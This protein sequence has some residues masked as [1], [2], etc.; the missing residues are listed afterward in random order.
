MHAAKA[1]GWCTESCELSSGRTFND[2]NHP[3]GCFWNQQPS[4][5]YG[6]SFNF[7]FS[8]PAMRTWYTA[9]HVHFVADGMDFWWNDEGET[10]WFT[11]LLWN[12]AQAMQFNQTAAVS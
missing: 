5:L 10:A 4:S 8:L 9:T 11:Y 2:S 7:N 1:L 12:E 6:T 3:P